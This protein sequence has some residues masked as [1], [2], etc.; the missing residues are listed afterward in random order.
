MQ[1][2]IHNI[3]LICDR[4][5]DIFTSYRKSGWI[6]SMETSNLHRKWNYGRLARTHI[7]LSS[8]ESVWFYKFKTFSTHCTSTCMII[9]LSVIGFVDEFARG[10]PLLFTNVLHISVC[11]RIKIR[12][13]VGEVHCKIF[14]GLLTNNQY[15][16][17][18]QKKRTNLHVF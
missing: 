16:I 18:S 13:F 14:H 5:V 9:V 4:I 8:E 2:K 3:T 12:R 1:S 15:V 6:N 10:F 11:Q 17:E 7:T